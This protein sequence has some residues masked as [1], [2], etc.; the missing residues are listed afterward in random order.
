LLLLLAQLHQQLLNI[1]LLPVV[2]GVFNMVPPE[3]RGAF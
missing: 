1:W 3:A 2:V